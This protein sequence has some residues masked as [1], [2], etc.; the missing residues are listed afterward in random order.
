MSS[1]PTRPRVAP[2]FGL[3]LLESLRDQDLPEEF[4]QDENPTVTMPRRLGLSDVVDRQIR[5][6]REAVRQ[7]RRM[8][9]D[10]VRDLLR[11]VG[12]RPDASELFHRAGRKLAARAAPPRLASMV[13]LLPKGLRFRLARRAAGRG[14]NRLFGRRVGGFA[15]GPFALEGRGLLFMEGD[16]T[17]RACHFVTGF[18]QEVVAQRL[19]PRYMVV[20]V[21]CQARRDP[22]CRWTVT[23]EARQRERDGVREMLLRPE[24]EAG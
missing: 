15:Y 5:T 1:A 16:P 9:D 2:I 22:V 21:Q 4:L 10:Q 3:T 24:L 7:R 18:C 20:H 19:G 13:G 17:G 23:G 11:L 14:L 12:R 6:Y 8:S